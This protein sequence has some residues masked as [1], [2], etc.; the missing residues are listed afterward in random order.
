MDETD[1]AIIR[2]LQNDGR[3]PY[4]EIAEYLKVSEGTVRNRVARLIDD[5]IL[6]IVGIADPYRLG[7]NS[8]AIIGI[9]IEPGHIEMAAAEIARFPE[10]SYLV[11]TAGSFDLLLEIFCRDNDHLVDFLHH[12]LQKVEGVRSTQTFMIL[13]TY[14]LSHQRGTP[15]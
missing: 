2:Y 9:G 8:P 7:Y 10:V 5:G 12:R 1:L 13:Q 15:S 3:R 14:K 6:H 11:V 4:T